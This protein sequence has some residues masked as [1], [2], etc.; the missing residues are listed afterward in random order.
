MP[1]APDI[2]PRYIFVTKRKTK[3][4][5]GVA[6]DIRVFILK[7][8][9]IH[10]YPSFLVTLGYLKQPVRHVH[11]ELHSLYVLIVMRRL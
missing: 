4:A 3:D 7:V 8:S 5:I 1:T 6:F 9:L 2:E 10:V 11:K